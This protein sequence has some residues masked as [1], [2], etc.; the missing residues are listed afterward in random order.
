VADKKKR[1]IREG[2][3]RSNA[4][5]RIARSDSVVCQLRVIPEL[6]VA[7]IDC[8][9]EIVELD[10]KAALLANGDDGAVYQP[11]FLSDGKFG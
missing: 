6:V 5:W 8:K 11:Y 1:P 9:A 3:G 4:R 2:I 10:I 7:L